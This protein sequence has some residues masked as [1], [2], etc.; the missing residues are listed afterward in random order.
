MIIAAELEEGTRLDTSTVKKLCSTDTI[1]A[2]KKYRDPFHF[3]PSHHVILYTNH[4]PKVGTNDAGTWARLVV[5][6]FNA[7]FRGQADEVKDYAGYL[8]EHCGGAALSWMIAGARRV[9]DQE[10]KITLPEA[11]TDAVK[12]YRS[13]NDWLTEFIRE[14]CVTG[15]GYSAAAPLYEEYK[16]FCEAYGEYKRG[17][18]EF[19]LTLEAAG[20]R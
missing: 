9:I 7:T 14:R 3:V 6:P 18:R 1:I 16:D 4:L 5:V 17:S 10:F 15:R 20:Y 11:V 19:F 13:N 8:Y 2:E 12:E